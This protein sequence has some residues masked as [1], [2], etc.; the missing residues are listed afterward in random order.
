M[1]YL[2][3]M[4]A[5]VG[6]PPRKSSPIPTPKKSSNRSYLDEMDELV[7][8]TPK[9][10]Y[11]SDT[12]KAES[13][14]EQSWPRFIAEQFSKGA[15][16]TADLPQVVGGFLE[17]AGPPQLALMGDY[18]YIPSED[19]RV[20]NKIPLAS[21]VAEKGLKK[22]GI[23]LNTQ[24]ANTPAKKIVG[25]G[26]NFA[27]S[28]LSGGGAGLAKKVI[29]SAQ[30]L[31]TFLKGASDLGR[32]MGISGAAGLGSGTAIELG[33][34]PLVADLVSSV[35]TPLAA[36]GAKKAL[37]IPLHIARSTVSP[38]Y[39]ESVV[40]AQAQ[41]EA[42]QHLQ[43]V[44]GNEKIGKVLQALDEP[45]S[46]TGFQGTTAEKTKNSA[47]AQLERA[48][49][50]H[51]PAIADIQ[52]LDDAAI[53]KSLSTLH[54][55]ADIT[56]TATHIT[57]EAQRA[58]ELAEDAL[59]RSKALTQ[60]QAEDALAEFGHHAGPAEAGSAIRGKLQ[61]DVDT[62]VA[63]RKEAVA[64]LYKEVKDITEGFR[65]E[66]TY[67]Y[68]EEALRDAR[69]GS[70]LEKN[71]Q[72]V[73]KMLVSKYNPQ[74]IGPR[75]SELLGT[76][77]EVDDLIGKAKKAGANERA[78]V[79]LD[80]KKNLLA[81]M[82][83]LPQEKEVRALYAKMSEPISA[84]TEHR[85]IGKILDRDQFNKEYI[86]KGNAEVPSL[87]INSSMKSIEDASDLAKFIGNDKKT[88]DAVQG[89]INN[90]I[91]NNITDFTGKV[92]PK[93][94]TQW[95]KTNQGAFH[96]Y[97][98]LETK[99]SNITNAQHMANE[100]AKRNVKE[101][102]GYYKEVLKAFSG[103]NPDVY[104]AKLLGGS[105]SYD[106]IKEAAKRARTDKTGNSLEGLRRGMID[107]LNKVMKLSSRNAENEANISYHNYRKFM[108]RNKRSLT[109]IF[110][111]DQIKLLKEVENNLESRTFG[112]TAAHSPGSPTKSN[113][114]LIKAIQD[115]PV[116]ML[117]KSLTRFGFTGEVAAFLYNL[118]QR[119]K[120]AFKDEILRKSLWDA[121]TTKLLL[122]PIKEKAKIESMVE[123]LKDRSSLMLPPV[124][125]NQKR[126]E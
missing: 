108:E 76:I 30:K 58:R 92:D 80:V 53:R 90:N 74:Q 110:D 6:R 25:R 1:S 87:V 68:L 36:T 112:S 24:V 66:K 37:D 81:D 78:K 103:E 121:E 70:P 101:V 77:K 45:P 22:I 119:T 99:L 94:I 85:T 123:Y 100:V 82:E 19:E 93:K 105:N 49:R 5:L 109:E 39:R 11:V 17:G 120:L 65:P 29:G 71:L 27:G 14:A 63:A 8:R 9:G 21:N 48:H 50:G 84:I 33:A 15:L 7:G 91:V 106:K 122:T 83:H 60:S 102:D 23:D 107:H 126:E 61:K 89:Y 95:S 31:P 88:M 86:V 116:G 98:A 59:A 2:D 38:K 72:K 3:E 20:L 64:P 43:D 40:R 4:D 79:L 73:E 111:E 67:S 18:S 104:I 47:I 115:L 46:F 118:T 13:G 35:V 42:A 57:S 114:V 10:A 97:P 51:V 56:D 32:L 28:V 26:A 124:V 75:P 113:D 16:T 69:P 34:N 44:V 54:K 96:L 117:K 12:P 55:E 62:L 52:A 125:L 41:K